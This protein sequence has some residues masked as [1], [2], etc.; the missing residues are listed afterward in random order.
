MCTNHSNY[1]SLLSHDNP[2]SGG[3]I[4]DLR[5]RYWPLCLKF[6][7]PLGLILTK[8]AGTDI[9][10]FRMEFRKWTTH[11]TLIQHMRLYI[12]DFFSPSLHSV[13]LPTLSFLPTH[14][15]GP[16][17][18][19][20]Q[21]WQLARKTQRIQPKCIVMFMAKVYYSERMQCKISKGKRHTG[22]SLEETRHELP[23]VLSQWS[24][25]RYT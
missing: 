12:F 13:S 11:S 20:P 16:S 3:Y 23:R 4:K 14:V 22:Q 19:H 15:E 18:N 7:F 10:Q 24:N 9:S 5:Q 6:L 25:I 8:I 2:C 21:V 17:Q 1:F